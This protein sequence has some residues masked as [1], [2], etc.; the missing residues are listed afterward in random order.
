M[1]RRVNWMLVLV[2]GLP[3]ASIIA[4]VGMI[5]V[6]ESDPS[7]QETVPAPTAPKPSNLPPS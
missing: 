4:G 6:A 2:V 7:A 1:S 3:L 5:L